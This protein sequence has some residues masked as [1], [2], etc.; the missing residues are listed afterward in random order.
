MRGIVDR[1]EHLGDD[2]GPED[3]PTDALTLEG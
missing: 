2:V 3:M 1:L